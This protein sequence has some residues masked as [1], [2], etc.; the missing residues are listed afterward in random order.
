MF[1]LL[2]VGLIKSAT[3]L[4]SGLDKLVFGK[5]RFNKEDLDAL[6]EL[7]IASDLGTEASQFVIEKLSGMRVHEASDAKKALGNIFIEMLTK[8]CISLSELDAP[9]LVLTV[10]GVNG[11][12]KTT[13]IGK[14]AHLHRSKRVIVGACDTFRAAAGAQLEV[15]CN[16][17][18]AEFI[19]GSDKQNSASIAFQVA[20]EAEKG[21]CMAIIDTAGRLPNNKPLMDELTRLSKA[22]GKAA[23]TAKHLGVLVI[24]A[25]IGQS[26]LTQV[27]AFT[28][29]VPIDAL[30]FTKM[31]TSAKGG[32]LIALA[33]KFSIPVM[34]LGTGEGI[35]DL[36]EFEPQEFVKALLQT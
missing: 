24:D 8:R 11:A 16:R 15:W 32:A 6:E 17:S 34:A 14:I 29:C 35:D 7:L 23:P 12:G 1:K 27:E 3:S 4:V 10:L 19:S 28:K 30:I 22:V 26:A 21:E 18:G 9:R 2:K 20:Q 36:A 31:D 13:V 33:H 5:E 25:S